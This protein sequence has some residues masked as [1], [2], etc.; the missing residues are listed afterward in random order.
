[1]SVYSTAL[2]VY[3]LLN[4]IETILLLNLMIHTMKVFKVKLN[5]RQCQMLLIS[6]EIPQN[7]FG[8]YPYL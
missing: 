2:H 1:M 5:D 6:Q 8:H 3:D 4:K 7:L